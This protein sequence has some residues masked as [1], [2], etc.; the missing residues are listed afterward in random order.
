MKI[1]LPKLN[2]KIEKWKWN[3]EFRIYVSTMGNFKDEYKCNLPIKISQKTGYCQILTPRG[4]KFAHRLVM[5]TWKPIP[6]AED[7]TVDHLNHNKRC[8][9]LWNLEWITEKEN[10]KRADEDLVDK[11]DKKVKIKIKKEYSFDTISDAINWVLHSQGNTNAKHKTIPKKEN[12]EN[13]I[14]NA[15]KNNVLYCGYKWTL[16]NDLIKVKGD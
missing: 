6:N 15:I 2:L 4:Y 11:F 3:K 14:Y 9:E 5:L 13:K 8:N 10:K 1:I 7:L 12:V 16:E